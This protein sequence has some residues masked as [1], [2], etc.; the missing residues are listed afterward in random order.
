MKKIKIKRLL[1]LILI[2]AVIVLGI[3]FIPKLFT[4]KKQ[5]VKEVDKLE[6]YNYTLNNNATSYYKKTYEELKK[7]L[8]NEPVNQEEYANLVSKLFVADFFNLDNKITNTDIGGIQFVYPEYQNTLV[9]L[10][11]DSIYKHV[12]NNL[13]NDRKQEL[14]KVT[15]VEIVTSQKI[16]YNYL[17]KADK[18][19]HEVKLKIKYEKDL[20]YQTEATIILINQEHKLVIAEMTK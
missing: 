4:K 5:V 12:K 6:K 15:E 9:K 20:K 16:K 7:L 2:I 17:D 3:I 1:I 13:Y 19:A 18:E 10:A 14:P 11:K 8:N